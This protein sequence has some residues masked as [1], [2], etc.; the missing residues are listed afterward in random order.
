MEVQ[1][2]ERVF[3]VDRVRKGSM[4]KGAVDGVL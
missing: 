1:I 2:K 4:D 3:L